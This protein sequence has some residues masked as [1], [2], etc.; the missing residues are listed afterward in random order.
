MKNLKTVFNYSESIQIDDVP[1]P[2]LDTKMTDVKVAIRHSTAVWDNLKIELIFE[3]PH[4][5]VVEIH[6]LKYLGRG[7][8]YDP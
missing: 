8:F 6:D 7:F 4:T 3:E 2:E 5:M 1:F